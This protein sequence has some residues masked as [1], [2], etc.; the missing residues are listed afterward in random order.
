M[1]LCFPCRVIAF[2]A[3]AF[4]LASPASAVAPPTEEQWA[5]LEASG[6]T[7]NAL[8][9]A[10]TLQ[11]DNQSAVF[12]RAARKRVEDA[13]RKAGYTPVPAPPGPAMAPPP[14]WRNLATTGTPRTLTL[15]VDFSDYRAATLHP[16]ISRPDI[17]YNIYGPGTQYSRDNGKPF[18]SVTDYWKRASQGKLNIKGDVLN[19]VHLPNA[20]ATYEPNYTDVEEADRPEVANQAYFDIAKAIMEA[21]DDDVDFTQYDNNNDGYIDT[22]NIIWTGPTGSWLSFWWPQRWS[23]YTADAGTTTFDGKKLGAF[24]W[25]NVSTR[26]GGDDFDPQVLCHETGHAL[27]F[28]DLY[29]YKKTLGNVGGVGGFDMMD[30][31]KGNPNGFFR[32]MMGWIDPVIVGGGPLQTFSLTASGNSTA[33]S[34]QAVVIFPNAASNE[35]QEF[36]LVE[37]RHRI[38]N[39]GGRSDL[40][41]DGLAIWHIDSTLTADGKDFAFSNTDSPDVTAHK[42]VRLVQA[43]GLNS[44]ETNAWKVDAGDY[45]NLGDSFGTNMSRNYAGN[46]TD[47]TVT[48]ISADGPVMTANI[49]FTNVAFAPNLASAGPQFTTVS[50]SSRAYGE[51]LTFSARIVNNGNAIAGPFRVEFKTQVV[52]NSWGASYTQTL[53]EQMINTP[54]AAGATTDV[55]F[56]LNIPNFYWPGN[57]VV[58]M[59]IDSQGNLS[60]STESDNVVTFPYVTITGAPA[61]RL[62]IT[63]AGGEIASGSNS[64]SPEKGTEFPPT[65][66][67]TER[68]LDYIIKNVGSVSMSFGTPVATITGPGASQFRFGPLPSSTQLA[69]GGSRNLSVVFAPTSAGVKSATVTVFSDDPQFPSYIFT[70][71]GSGIPVDDFGNSP[72]TASNV[73]PGAAVN[74]SIGHAGDADYF[75]IVVPQSGTLQVWTTGT[76][77]TYGALYNPNGTEVGSNDDGGGADGSNFRILRLVTPGTWYVMVRAYDAVTTGSYTLNSQFISTA[78]DDY[79]NTAGTAHDLTLEPVILPGRLEAA[80]DVDCFRFMPGASGVLSISSLGQTDTTA[81]LQRDTAA[82]FAANDSGGTESNFSMSTVVEPGIYYLFLRGANASTTG[83]YQ[84]QVTFNQY[85]APDDHGNI[86]ETATAAALNGSVSGVLDYTVD[87]DCF[88]V[89]VTSDGVLTVYT[90]GTRD[91]L[92]TILAG[93]SVV[94]NDDSAGAKN[95]GISQSVTARNYQVRVAAYNYVNLGAYTL[96]TNFRAAG[97]DDFANFPS[98]SGNVFPMTGTVGTQGANL[99]AGGDVDFYKITLA[100]EGLLTVFTSGTTDTYG[101][102]R[103]ADGSIVSQD[104]DAGGNGK[105]FLIQRYLPAGTYFAE[106]RGYNRATTTGSYTMRWNLALGA[107]PD[108]HG[109]SISTATRLAYPTTQT[110]LLN[111]SGDEDYFRIYLTQPTTLLIHTTGLIDN[112][113][114]LLDSNGGEIAN[115]DDSGPDSNYSMAITLGAGTYFVKTLGFNAQ[116]SGNYTL[117]VQVLPSFGITS[118]TRAGSTL[119]LTWVS[120]AAYTYRIE[121]ATSLPGT[122]SILQNNIAGSNA[123]SSSVDIA[124][125][126]GEPRRFYRVSRAR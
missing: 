55:S 102:L 68:T 106:A 71:Q 70:V 120:E 46:L 53:S 86:Q 44:I 9:H 118:L 54:L 76:L 1:N 59:H 20:R 99:E 27:G 75:K 123:G 31:N 81:F 2:A 122:W 17:Y 69:V 124:I 18:D 64:P 74:G 38:G 16:N 112:R 56:T 25:L 116:T 24:T 39:D 114:Q 82:V 101:V 34:N 57:L 51:P 66:L 63:G 21:S 108:D 95:F 5:E 29:D 36:F 94:E 30:G 19:W 48:S 96:E 80:G 107:P 93:G 12:T 72:A 3:A 103:N 26:N 6:Q 126:A 110:G 79:G 111:Y 104:D 61:P 49:G 10:R 60:E 37:N 28:P 43:D 32:W 100:S 113:G 65:T 11:K 89:P 58:K 45:W 33:T 4:L 47:A 125:V 84:L 90:T 117:V 109:N 98:D 42:L 62:L 121:T 23:L 13:A 92:G 40:P 41:S 78:T 22:I 8:A 14:N 73:A 88:A 115:D 105:N 52:Y 77:D 35:F 67:S 50:A 85:I 97:A 119:K 7:E 15:L 83:A 87:K 91:T